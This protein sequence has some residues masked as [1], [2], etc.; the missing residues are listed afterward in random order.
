MEG[1]GG[2][3]WFCELVVCVDSAC[4]EVIG[5]LR[6]ARS[7]FSSMNREKRLLFHKCNIHKGE[8]FLVVR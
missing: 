2:S 8:N 4:R 1:R 6:N 5:R 7:Y 3:K